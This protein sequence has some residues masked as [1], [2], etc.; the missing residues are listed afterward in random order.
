MRKLLA[1]FATLALIPGCATGWQLS[2]SEYLTD[3]TSDSCETYSTGARLQG[4]HHGE[5]FHTH[6]DPFDHVRMR[7]FADIGNR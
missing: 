6:S 5:T 2:V 3:V 1:L 7:H 4:I